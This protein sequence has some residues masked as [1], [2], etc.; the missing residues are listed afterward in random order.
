MK[1]KNEEKLID[2]S[3]EESASQPELSDDSNISKEHKLTVQTSHQAL[4][5]TSQIAEGPSDVAGIDQSA[6]SLIK[7]PWLRLIQPTSQK[8]E[9]KSGK[10][11]M[12]GTYLMSDS[13][14]NYGTMKF[15]ILRAKRENR[16]FE[17]DGVKTPSQRL[18][19]LGCTVPDNKLFILSLSVTSFS[20]WGRLLSQFKDMQLDKTWRFSINL[21]S[22]KIENDKGKFYVANF[23]LDDEL[24][25]EY[26]EEMQQKALEYGLVLDRDF[27]EEEA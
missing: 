15:V 9:D 17:R 22:E 20:N 26:I 3:I 7:L 5:P 21:S 11:S 10:E 14:K 24:E 1:N 19:I 8:T 25:P 18:A 6:M 23:K 27:V 2:E 16:E 12:P 4:A 13:L